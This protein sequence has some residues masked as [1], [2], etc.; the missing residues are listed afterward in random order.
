MLIEFADFGCTACAAFARETLPR[1]EREWIATGRA[2][3]RV[4]PID[5]LR[6]GRLAARAG[7]CAAEQGKFWPMQN[8]L[9]LQQRA[10][11]GKRGQ[12]DKFEE[13]ALK[14]GV[15]TSRF[16]TCW[17]NEENSVRL[18]RNTELAR[19]HGVPGTPAFL[20]NGKPAVGAL[21]YAFFSAAL[22]SAADRRSAAH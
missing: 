9:F 19:L 18:I 6:S 12:H 4:I 7:Q 14:I 3:L 16:R 1:L 13:F 10:W 2:R 20:V 15:D 22:D 5:V 8:L 21:P 17:K 11:L